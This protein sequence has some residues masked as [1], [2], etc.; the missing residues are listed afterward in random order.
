MP[1]KESSGDSKEATAVPKKR[2]QIKPRKL[3]FLGGGP[4]LI[5]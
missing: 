2:P 3:S 1:N 4:L 5:S